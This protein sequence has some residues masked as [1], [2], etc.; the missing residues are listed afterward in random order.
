M[1]KQLL[2]T[3]RRQLIKTSSLLAGSIAT[4]NALA[5]N[6]SPSDTPRVI[7]VHVPGGAIAE[8]WHPQG[9]GDDFALNEM[10]APF[11]PVKQHCVF[12]QG[13]NLVD[14]GHGTLWRQLNPES[15]HSESL[16]IRLAKHFGEDVPLALSAVNSSLDTMTYSAEAGL[17][18]AASNMESVFNALFSQAQSSSP[19]FNHFA[20]QELALDPYDFE[21]QSRQMLELAV[22][23][24]QHNKT[25]VASLQLGDDEGNF[26][27]P[28]LGL[29]IDYAQALHAT[30]SPQAFIA[31]RQFLSE[32]VAYLIKLLAATPDSNGNPLI[33]STLVVQVANM[34]D[35]RSHT[36]TDAPVMLAG[37]KQFIKNGLVI[38]P[39]AGANTQRELLDTV[40]S[41]LGLTGDNY[42]AG[43][44]SSLLL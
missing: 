11:E 13:I 23:G 28:S 8:R 3:T 5:D 34:G 29:D 22:L 20:Q 21:T 4:A 9:C 7:F 42:G 16:D 38:R 39:P 44:I 35:G 2:S 12:L 14:Y 27:L 40:S 17:I 25:R 33:D 26:R 6:V 37:G 30:A 43:P 15:S 41:A 18:P 32:R 19:L 1:S 10:S 36:G 31:F 24:L